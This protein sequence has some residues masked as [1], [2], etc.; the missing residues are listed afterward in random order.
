MPV[1]ALGPDEPDIDP[2]AFV[3]PDAVVI[4]CVSIGAEASVWPGAVLRGDLGRIAV[5]ARTSVQ[6]GTVVHT[7]PRWPT[8]I[9]PDC[10]IGH[11][12]HLEGCTV[13]RHA[14]IGSGSVVLNRATVREGAVVGAC[15]LVPE[16]FEIPARTMALGVPARLRETPV[17]PSWVEYAVRTY[18]DNG[19]RYRRE[20]HR[21]DR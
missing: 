14:L 9:G 8:L 4:G 16:D 21:I 6:D 18:R 15:A 2:S 11:N 5:G 1:Y 19:A 17:D 10:V 12:A 20:L 13:E 7:T 3:H